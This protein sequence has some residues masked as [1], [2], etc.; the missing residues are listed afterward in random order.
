M[1]TQ[2]ELLA[3]SGLL[4]ERQAQVYLLQNDQSPYRVDRATTSTLLGLNEEAIE[5]RYKDAEDTISEALNGLYALQKITGGKKSR[6]EIESNLPNPTHED[7]T[8]VEQLRTERNGPMVEDLG[9][10]APTRNVYLGSSSFGARRSKL[11]RQAIWLK[12]RYAAYERVY[13]IDIESSELPAD[14]LDDMTLEEAKDKCAVLGS[15]SLTEPIPTVANSIDKL[16]NGCT[17]I[18]YYADP[19]DKKPSHEKD[20][21]S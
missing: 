6:P 12:Q 4:T 9:N 2:A 13:A 21:E 7:Q 16:L 8:Q 14:E 15:I 3:E 11:H 18:W 20:V 1:T 17:V 19:E 5:A 10:E